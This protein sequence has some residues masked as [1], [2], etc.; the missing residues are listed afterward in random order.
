MAIL[1]EC[2]LLL[3]LHI[4]PNCA[5]VL[6]LDQE[7]AALPSWPPAHPAQHDAE[8]RTPAQRLVFRRLAASRTCKSS[9]RSARICHASQEEDNR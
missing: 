2:S 1:I 9:P 6:P 5:V 4:E 7:L 3:P 8:F